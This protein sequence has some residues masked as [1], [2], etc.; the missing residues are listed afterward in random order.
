[1]R[2]L[3][4]GVMV[5]LVVALPTQ[6]QAQVSPEQLSP[7]IGKYTET[8]SGGRFNA[9]VTTTSG[10]IATWYFGGGCHVNPFPCDPPNP[11]GLGNSPG[12]QAVAALWREDGKEFVGDVI[13]TNQAGVLDTGPIRVRFSLDGQL[14]LIQGEVTRVLDRAR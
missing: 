2:R 8:A 11:G 1:M 13:S 5:A 4:F 9:Y 6:A 12:G 7:I 3:L 14:I 10:L